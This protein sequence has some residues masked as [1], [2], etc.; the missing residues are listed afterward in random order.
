MIKSIFKVLPVVAV[1]C[2]T[3]NMASAQMQT[4]P[5]KYFRGNSITLKGGLTNSY[6]DIRTAQFGWHKAGG[7][8]E[9]KPGFGVSLNHMFSSVFGVQGNFTYNQILGI[10]DM[11]TTIKEYKNV[12]K[13][14]G[15]PGP[16][17]FQTN[18]IHGSLSAYVNLTNLA[19]GLAKANQK[20]NHGRRFG[21]YT[22][23]GVGMVN[24]ET[25][26]KDLP[27]DGIAEGVSYDKPYVDPVTG[28]NTGVGG[29]LKGKSG[30]NT[31]EVDF[32]FSVGVKY[33]LSKRIDLGLEHTTH[34]I[35]TDKLDGYAYFPKSAFKKNNDKFSM[36]ALTLT[37]K[38]S[39]KDENIDYI[40]WMDPTEVMYDDYQMLS[41]KLRKLST[42]TDNDGVADIFDK[43]PNTPAGAIVD[44]A[45]R[46]VDSDGDGVPDYKDVDPFSPKGATV[47]ADGKAVD[48]DGDGVPDVLDKEPNTKPGS[49][50]NQEGKTIKQDFATKEDLKNSGGGY[51]PP[52]IY[53]DNNSSAIKPVYYPELA[54][55]AKFIKQTGNAVVVTGH[56]DINGSES[57][58]QKLGQKR[59]D[60]VKEF[61]VKY[62]SIDAA[63]IETKS[64]GKTK[65]LYKQ[66]LQV[67]RRVE[68]EVKK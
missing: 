22:A 8:S 35:M 1:L 5:K 33:K 56:T 25:V 54:S 44:G 6:T 14:L 61:L 52:T 24:F 16:V 51:V 7:K 55:L 36:S 21:L 62:Y 37:Y 40:E 12:Y 11:D 2:V 3:A 45:G 32:P 57:S 39:G 10:S 31:T 42:D 26:V 4:S 66:N 30:P 47:D 17:Y 64:E 60:A 41:D 46:A 9:M 48:T 53:F 13:N 28:K 50:V 43:E 59:A 68:V 27:G 58:N 49:L 18:V 67:N 23:L 65:Q 38:F 34:F 19:M 15:V 20:G 29:Y 63:K